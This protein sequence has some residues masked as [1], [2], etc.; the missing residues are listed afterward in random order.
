MSG[1]GRHKLGF[2]IPLAEPL[3]GAFYLRLLSDTWLHVSG[4]LRIH[5]SWS[6]FSP[7]PAN[8]SMQQ[9]Q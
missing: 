1:E 6:N 2:T 8:E 3:P 4:C 5:S 9:Q 7:V